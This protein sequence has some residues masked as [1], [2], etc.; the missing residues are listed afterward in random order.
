MRT[1][2]I[3]TPDASTL[4]IHPT[5][6]LRALAIGRRGPVWPVLGGSGEGDGNTGDVDP[7]DDDTDDDATDKTGDQGSSRTDSGQDKGTQKDTDATKADAKAVKDLPAWAQ[8]IIRSTRKEA[9]DSRKAVAA[10]ETERQKQLDAIATA[11]GLKKGEEIDPA[12]LQAQLT[13]ERDTAAAEATEARRELAVFKA[14]DK[15][16]ANASE[17]LDSRTFLKDVA[18]LDP[19][20]KGFDG[21]VADL[22]KAAVKENPTKFGRADG[23]PK[24]STN[25]DD[26]NGGKGKG[27]RPTSLHAALAARQQT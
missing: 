7:D 11:L 13:T 8:R 26:M 17:L 21:E 9:E 6:G 15:H 27:P 5:T 25:A 19:T 10:A 2:T 18:A 1:T 14:A 12:K 16:G 20:D 23:K 3:G 4:P 22:I 24:R